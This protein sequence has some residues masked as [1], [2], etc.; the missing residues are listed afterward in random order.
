MRINLNILHFFFLKVLN[1]TL[2]SF[3]FKNQILIE[4]QTFLFHVCCILPLIELLFLHCKHTVLFFLLIY[5][6]NLL[7]SFINLCS[8]FQRSFDLNSLHLNYLMNQVTASKVNQVLLL[9]QEV[10]GFHLILFELISHKL[11]FHLCNY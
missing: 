4:F 1:N 10:C 6:L 5:L 11:T 9:F 2:H 7:F 8:F 3:L